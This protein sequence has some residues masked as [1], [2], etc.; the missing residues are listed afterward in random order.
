MG[1]VPAYSI[2]DLSITKSFLKQEGTRW[3]EATD[4][5]V[6]DRV[7]VNLTIVSR[8][9]M[10]YVA[11][12]DNRAACLEPVEQTPAPVF[13]DGLCFYRQNGDNATMLFISSLP[14]GTYQLGYDF[15]V[16][17]A[18]SFASGTANI[19]SQYAP[20]LSA[21]SS[22]TLLNVTPASE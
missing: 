18:G 7:R 5:K 2:P 22:G 15:W 11:V 20:Q 4:L 17:S 9:A 12:T 19:Q 16:N 13:A 3:V 1:A 10:D 6:G 14:A 8:R 21:H